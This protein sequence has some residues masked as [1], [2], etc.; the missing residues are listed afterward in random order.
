MTYKI[1]LVED[2]PV[3]AQTVAAHLAMWGY[4]VRSAQDFTRVMEE[5][6]AFSP[7]LVLLDIGL[8]HCSGYSWCEE[9]RR[10]SKAPVV[11]L[12]SAADNM[13][14]ITAMNLGGD[15]FIPKPFD[16]SVLT[17]K[18]Q[19]VL[20]RAYSLQGSVNLIECAGAALDLAAATLSGPG[21]KKELTK[22]EVRI[23]QLLMENQGR[24]VSRRD[25]M[26]RL[27]ESESFID[28][29]TLSV[30]VSRLRRKLEQVGLAGLLHTRKGQGYI[31]GQPL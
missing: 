9:I 23:L 27:W 5:F 20:R 8:P 28:D 3:I 16:L 25:L 11:F 30:N 29:N 7:H 4:E 31:L 2:D 10:R 24:P 17:A 6:A 19:A 1:F 13:N 21:G 26:A 15:D 12:S 14:I 22:N 18:V